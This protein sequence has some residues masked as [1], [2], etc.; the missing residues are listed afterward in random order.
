MDS[1]TY[2]VVVDKD[3]D[4]YFAGYNKFHSDIRKAV[5]YKYET[6]AQEI[7]DDSRFNNKNLIIGKAYIERVE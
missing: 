4:M 3:T 2:F 6:Y 1:G 5:F 7:L